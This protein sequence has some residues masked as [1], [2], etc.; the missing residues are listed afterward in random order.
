M[1]Q[2]GA[3][4]QR[5]RKAV[6]SISKDDY[7]QEKR[8][9]PRGKKARF[10]KD[11]TSFCAHL[12]SKSQIKSGKNCAV[13]N[14]LTFT[15][16]GICGVALHFPNGRS[17]VSDGNCVAHYHDCSYFG[18]AACDY[19]LRGLPKKDWVKPSATVINAN[20]ALIDQFETNKGTPS[21]LSS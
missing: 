1:S 17:D 10:C 15:G 5:K 6:D 7:K 16:C 20:A 19:K 14:N 4:S 3:G 2:P 9:Q 11:F 12:N 8:E 21:S 13:C 18:L